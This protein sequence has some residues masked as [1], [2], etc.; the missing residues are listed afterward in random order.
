MQ[1]NFYFL[2]HLSP[3]LNSILKGKVL[4]ECFCQNKDELIVV[5]GDQSNDQFKFVIKASL[6]PSFTCLVFPEHF[7]RANSNSTDI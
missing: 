3:R 1:N 7:S 6:S 2:S 5:F 4:S